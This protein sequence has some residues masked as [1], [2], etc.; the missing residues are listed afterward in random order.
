MT[1]NSRVIPL[2][3]AFCFVALPGATL[4]GPPFV[5]DDPEPV[6]YQHWEINIA[7]QSIATPAGWSGT[8]P[9]LDM[10]YGLMPDVQLSL[11]A[12][13]AYSAPSVGPAHYGYG[14]TQLAVKWRFFESADHTAEAAI[15]PQLNIPT[16]R[17]SSGLGNGHP[18]GFL[19]LWL[20]KNLD[21]WTM[22][23]GGGYGINSGAGNENWSLA[24]LVVQRQIA[25]N[26]A[27]GAEVYHLTP[28]V[29]GQR[30]DTAFNVGTVI[31]FSERDH[32][33]FS[34]G[35][36]IDGPTDFQLYVAW[37]ITI[38]PEFFRA[39]DFGGGAR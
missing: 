11:F 35:R 8:A 28:T 26:F 4:A 22:Y 3:V 24:G 18:Q 13:M 10:N 15:E 5:T 30:A 17:E 36:S 1:A 33:L 16:G 23:G 12:P 31:D 39:L 29:I 25:K 7:S 32:L 6:D 20:Q 21:D 19:P 38:G 27:L 9:H 37:Q 14:D 34:V 2:W